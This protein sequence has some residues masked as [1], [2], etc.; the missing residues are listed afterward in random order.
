MVSV[1]KSVRLIVNG[2]AAG[3]EALRAAVAFQRA[4]GHRI[5]VRVTWE[6]G[7]ARRFAAEPGEI[8]VLGAVGGDGT[9]NEVVHG[10]MTLPAAARPALGVVPMGTANDFAG[11]CHIPADPQE[12]L[13]L[14]IGGDPVTVDVGKANDRWFVNVASG[15]FGA[16][17]TAT[18]PPELK[19]LLGG[20][21][22]TLMGVILAVN[23][24]PYE[25]RLVLP[26]REIS[27]A[28]VVAIMANGRQTGGGK[29]V[30]PRAFLDDGLLD[31]LVVREIPAKVLPTA[32]RE[33]QALSPDGRFI[34]YFQAPWAEFHAA[35]TVPVNLDGEPAQ[36]AS[37]RYEAVPAALRL[38]V[39]P[40]CPMIGAPGASRVRGGS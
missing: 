4:A 30:A 13:A 12:A 1:T 7:D 8:E 18:T 10:L 40:D 11:G 16:T 32:A 26:D 37:V 2:K 33:L 9:V 35:S 23:F 22:Y 28:G 6:S 3:S 19:R 31:V 5:E 20:A 24:R 25:G 21:A 15:G 27:G 29:Q 34:S 17:V 36:F 39:P 14:C 38:I